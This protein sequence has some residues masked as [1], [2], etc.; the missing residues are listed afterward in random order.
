VFVCVCGSSPSGYISHELS[1]DENI[2]PKLYAQDSTP[3][4]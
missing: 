1:R 2:E 3:K 4:P